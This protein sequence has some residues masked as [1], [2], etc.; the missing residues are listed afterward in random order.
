MPI[1][2]K[3]LVVLARRG[4]CVRQYAPSGRVCRGSKARVRT[5]D[6]RARVCV[7]LGKKCI[8]LQ[9]VPSGTPPA[10]LTC[11]VCIPKPS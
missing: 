1:Q 4:L 10:G 7:R 8:R 11:I 5:C 2:F 9:V 3:E 6:E